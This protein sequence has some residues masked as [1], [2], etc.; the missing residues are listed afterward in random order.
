MTRP[1]GI[2]DSGVGG[3]SIWKEVA[4]ML[5]Y[6]N[7]I[8]LAD[9][10]N[11]PYG[12]KSKEEILHLSIKNT[13][14]L[15]NKGCKIVIVACNT[16]T[17]NA[18]DY[19]RSHYDIPF[20]GIEPAIKPAAFH[21]K[22]KKVGVLATK[23]TLSSSLFHN[24]SKLF[25][26]GITVLEQEGKGLVELIEAGK[27]QSEETKKLLSDFLEPMLEQQMDCLVLGCT[28]YP[29][30]MPVLKDILPK[31]ITIIDSGEAVARQTKAVLERNGLLS[32]GNGKPE[33][34]FY[35]NA[36]VE[37]LKNLIDCP[38]AQVSNLDF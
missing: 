18:I 11:A 17:T 27:I 35:T 16:A 5:P 9:S 3:T 15:L 20:I 8:Y 36:T 21:T 23:G 26:E 34:I 33:H 25:A 1:I 30:L 28:H 6:E 24:T 19:L 22:T 2:F 14:L 13:E 12:E 29:Y 32:D 31:G 10:A 38:S 4:K 7:T 37:V